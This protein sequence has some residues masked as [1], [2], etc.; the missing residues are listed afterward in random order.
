MV[1][2]TSIGNFRQNL[3]CLINERLG[4]G[5]PK[6][7]ILN[8]FSFPGFR[9]VFFELLPRSKYWEKFTE[10]PLQHCFQAKTTGPNFSGN[11][12]LL[13]TRSTTPTSLL[14]QQYK[15]IHDKSWPKTRAIKLA[16]F[17]QPSLVMTSKQP[18]IVLSKISELGNKGDWKHETNC[19]AIFFAKTGPNHGKEN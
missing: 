16:S 11:I 8:Q 7:W 2:N 5:C 14:L 1:Y 10:N 4:V 9:P 12:K 13:E 6:A 3:P 18:C 15:I 19:L 17:G